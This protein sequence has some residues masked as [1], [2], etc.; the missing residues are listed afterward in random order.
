M[1]N[2]KRTYKRALKENKR[3]RSCTHLQR[4]SDAV[5]SANSS[6]FWKVWNKYKQG[7][8]HLNVSSLNAN[9]CSTIIL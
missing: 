5:D 3:M 9:D 7:G 2:A 6:N 4:M 1:Q 8:G